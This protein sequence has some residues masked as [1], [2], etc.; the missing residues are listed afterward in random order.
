M[1]RLKIALIGCGYWGKNLARNLYSLGVLSCVV[2]SDESQAC[3]M[4]NLYN[5]PWYS[6]YKDPRLLDLEGVVIAVPPEYHYE[7]AKHFIGYAVNVFVEKPFTTTLDEAKELV[8]LADKANLVLMVG[9]TFLY[10]NEIRYIKDYIDKGLLGD[11]YS[12]TTRRLNLGIIQNRCN[13]VWDLAPHDIAVFNYLL[14][15]T[16]PIKI[17]G[18]ISSFLGRGIEEE[19]LLSLR[20][21]HNIMCN[22]HLSWLHPRKVRDT[23]IVGSKAMIVYDMLGENKISIYDK[24]VSLEDIDKNA[25]NNYG[26][27]LL[28]Y[29]YGDIVSPF[30]KVE[31]PLYKEL[32]EFIQCI[33]QGWSPLSDGKVGYNVIE[34]L[35]RIDKLQGVSY[36][37]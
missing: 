37:V 28:S 14:D 18:T 15:Q 4:S 12:I 26:S 24:G 36:A 19:A 2:D 35:T 23:V 8:N 10:V 11:I 33:Q 17:E 6:S 27:H 34:T 1:S 25:S 29:R 30:I 22:L 3:E 7:I 13:V 31:E 21:K 32:V 20:Y 5:V 16:K 9:H